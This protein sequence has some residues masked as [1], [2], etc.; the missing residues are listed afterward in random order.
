MFL[1]SLIPRVFLGNKGFSILLGWW[2]FMFLFKMIMDG[3]EHRFS[4]V[5]SENYQLRTTNLHPGTLNIHD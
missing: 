5:K 1:G 2:G 4:R 3:L